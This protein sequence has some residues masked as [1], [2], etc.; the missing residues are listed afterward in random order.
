M[1]HLHES[2]KVANEHSQ[3][4]EATV[5]KRFR[6]RPVNQ[7]PV[8]FADW[9][10]KARHVMTLTLVA[11]DIDAPSVEF[12]VVIDNGVGM[13]CGGLTGVWGR[14]CAKQTVVDRRSK[15]KR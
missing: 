4:L 2:G 11:R 15:L 12:V 13:N 5:R 6:F 9:R 10:K 8:D 14:I 1:G 7:Y 3:Y